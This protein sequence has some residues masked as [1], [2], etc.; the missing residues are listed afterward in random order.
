[1]IGYVYNRVTDPE[2]H[3]DLVEDLV[4]EVFLRVWT[5]L[6]EGKFEGSRELD[7]FRR[8]VCAV[9]RMVVEKYRCDRA[10]QRRSFVEAAQEA[11]L[12]R[13]SLPPETGSD[14]VR[15]DLAQKLARLSPE[16][17]RVVQLRHLEG[18]P[19]ATVAEV[20]GR[21]VNS[22]QGL[23]R[24]ALAH[25]RNGGSPRDAVTLAEV[26]ELAGVHRQ[27]ALRAL[28]CSAKV[29]CATRE[30]VLAAATELGYQSGP[31][32][33]AKPAA[34]PVRRPRDIAADWLTGYLTC[35]GTVPF[36][37]VSLDARSADISERTLRRAAD[38]AGVIRTRVEPPYGQVLWALPVAA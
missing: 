28:N 29:A 8:W 27:T 38:R 37:Q 22:V 30:R 6:R 31:H 26:A 10:E 20:M 13:A 9:A 25:L 11:R 7:G 35:H 17:R 5:A 1:V 24:T 12:N 23:E 34:K 21:T 33:C 3:R 14:E 32:V 18:L 19:V 4:Q 15:G 36:H 16:H 2:S